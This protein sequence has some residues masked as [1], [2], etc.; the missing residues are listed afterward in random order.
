MGGAIKS[1]TLKQDFLI[2][3]EGTTSTRKGQHQGSTTHLA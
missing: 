1:L 3:C 2:C